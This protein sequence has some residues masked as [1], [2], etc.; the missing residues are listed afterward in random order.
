MNPGRVSVASVPGT[1]VKMLNNID[2]YKIL[3]IGLY[4]DRNCEGYRPVRVTKLAVILAV[5]GHL[6]TWVDCTNS[7]PDSSKFEESVGF[8]F[9]D[10]KFFLLLWGL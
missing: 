8:Y 1:I 4:F 10:D 2:F 3:V 6:L 9:W 5:H 7:L